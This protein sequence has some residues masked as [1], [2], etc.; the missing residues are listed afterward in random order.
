MNRQSLRAATLV[1]ALL[2]LAV[3][4]IVTHHRAQQGVEWDVPVSGY[5]PRDLL[6][7]HYIAY[8]YDW[9]G[10][11][12]DGYG[13][14]KE[15]LCLDGAPPTIRRAYLAPEGDCP[16]PVSG[17]DDIWAVD[18]GQIYVP[19][20]QA[21]AMEAKLRDPKLQAMVRFRLRP[22]GHITPLAM[23]FRPRPAVP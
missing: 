17:P 22:D 12:R 5:D 4:W 20:T 7:G 21:S 1:F 13:N 15:V 10:F 16:Y 9:P 3:A 23:T 19:Q 6:R 2:G 18:R 8:Q 14:G 11:K